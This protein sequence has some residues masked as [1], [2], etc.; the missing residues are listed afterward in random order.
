MTYSRTLRFSPFLLAFTAACSSASSSSIGVPGGTSD[1][2]GGTGSGYA[3]ADPTAG[4]G[5]GTGNDTAAG[6][7]GE[8]EAG[9]LTEGMW[10]DNL[11]Y[12]FFTAYLAKHTTLDGRPGFT[13]SDYDSS[14]QLFASRS[15]STVVDAALVIDTTGSMGDEMS[16]L[17]AEFANI[18]QAISSA[19]PGADQHWALVLYRDRPDTD[20]GDDYV[21]RSIDFTSDMSAFSASIGAQQAA[22]GG[23]YPESPDLGLKALQQLSW[24]SGN[25]VAKV[26]FWVADAPDHTSEAENL[27][28]SI[29]GARDLG[30]HI[31]PVAASGTDDLLEYSMRS[32]AQITGGRYGFLTDDSG[33]GDSHKVPEIPCFFVTRLEKGL[34]RAIGMEL[35]GTYIAPAADTILR[36]AGNPSAAGQCSLGEDAGSVTIF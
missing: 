27:K 9:V 13:Q 1:I 32:A 21:V 11:N 20:P 31:Y 26:A 12:D 16:Y 8:G 25:D 5:G 18:A 2:A 33:I 24:R 19:Y 28:A 34:I 30:V 4:S 17:T 6:D 23:D 29:E 35:S 15:P 10:D 3:S 36:T 22:N 7:G 14:H